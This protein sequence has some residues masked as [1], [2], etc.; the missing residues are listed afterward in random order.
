MDDVR[1][2]VVMETDPKY[3]FAQA[4]LLLFL[5]GTSSRYSCAPSLLSPDGQSWT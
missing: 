4:E 2:V 3:D 1:D 5:P